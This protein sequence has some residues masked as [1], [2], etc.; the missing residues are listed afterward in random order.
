MNNDGVVGF[1]DSDTAAVGNNGDKDGEGADDANVVCAV[2]TEYSTAEDTT[3]EDNAVTDST[4]VVEDRGAEGN[5][6]KTLGLV[7]TGVE[8]GVAMGFG[9]EVGAAGV[10]EGVL[11]TDV[12]DTGTVGTDAVARDGDK[13]GACTS[14]V[15]GVAVE[16]AEDGEGVKLSG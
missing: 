14:V 16:V 13:T 12:V 11:D 8:A 10:D 4:G 2:P 1:I 9:V 3:N 15:A 7:A 5:G 6:P